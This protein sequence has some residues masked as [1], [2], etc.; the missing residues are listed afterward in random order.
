[1][2]LLGALSHLPAE[3]V[4]E[5]SRLFTEFKGALTEQYVCQQLSCQGLEPSYWSSD[6]GR[7]EVD[8]AVELGDEPIPIEV[9]AAENLRSKSLGVARDKFGL[10]RC[11]RTSLSGYRDEGW[12]V[13]V[14]L[15]AVSA[16]A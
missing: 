14:P 15:W 2:G 10:K 8:F 5:G 6:T 3:A 9:K 16:I 1:M 13:N 4:L 7:A 12:L 11:V